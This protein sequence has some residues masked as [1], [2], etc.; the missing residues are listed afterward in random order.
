VEKTVKYHLNR[1]VINPFSVM[2]VLGAR[3]MWN[4]ENSAEK[5]PEDLIPAIKECTKWFAISAERNAKFLSGP[6]VTN[7]FIAANVLARETKIKVPTK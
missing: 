5:I 2:T 1:L 4:R 6:R 3:E 7:R